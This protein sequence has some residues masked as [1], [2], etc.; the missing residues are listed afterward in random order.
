[1]GIVLI[2]VASCFA[3]LS[4]FSMRRS[5]DSGGTTKAFL[6]VQLSIAA[7]IALFLG[8]IRTGDYSLNIPVVV[9][10]LFCG[11]IL[12][13]MVLS[14]GRALEK[15]PPGLT[16]ATLNAS[17][18]MPAIVMTAF[19]GAAFGYI[20]T[21][22]HAAGSL[23]VLAG[24]FWAGKGLKDLVDRR[25]WLIFSALTF[26]LHI[27][28]LVLMQ[29]RALILNWPRPEEIGTTFSS[30]EISSPWFMFF[31][32]LAAAFL[33]IGIYFF[34]ERRLPK[35]EEC[36]YGVFGGIG[37]SLSTFFLI[38]ATE[39]ANSSQNAVLFPIFSISI[40]IICNVWGQRLYQEQVNW[41]ACQ[42]CL[43]GLFVGTVDWPSFLVHFGF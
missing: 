20:Y 2:L 30:S 31:I 13:I 43:F 12:G 9:L 14:L 18:V 11:L 28:F 21:P 17:T 16:F 6:A 36:F 19:F 4:N 34:T 7:L 40:I 3:S 1:M 42:L 35:K 10:G 39:A 8:P 25:S 32:Y 15:G 38:W 26:F 29:W 5:I 22:W 37:N 33:Q 23:L 27:L 24:L 41:K